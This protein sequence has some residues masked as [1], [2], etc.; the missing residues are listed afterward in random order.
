MGKHANASKITSWSCGVCVS[1]CVCV[2]FTA[3]CETAWIRT[4]VCSDAS[5]TEMQSLIPLR[6]CVC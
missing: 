3:E 6:P 5:C 4:R 1:M 2:T